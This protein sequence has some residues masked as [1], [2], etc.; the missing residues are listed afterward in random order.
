[1]RGGELS[2][3]MIT[4]NTVIN[5]GLAG[6]P[7]GKYL[8]TNS[9]TLV[10]ITL[11]SLIQQSWCIIIIMAR[12]YLVLYVYYKIVILIHNID[13]Y[14]YVIRKALA[15]HNSIYASMNARPLFCLGHICT[16]I[17]DK[18]GLCSASFSCLSR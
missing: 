6:S 17:R 7:A 12:I 4:L 10:Y 8:Y 11:Y 18:Y 16:H 14:M 15:E 5:H 13:N 2:V 1:M 3:L 9:L